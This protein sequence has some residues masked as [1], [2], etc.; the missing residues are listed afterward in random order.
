LP[1]FVLGE[2]LDGVGDGIPD[3]APT[4]GAQANLNLSSC[5]YAG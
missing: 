4:V 3:E 5:L 1:A 2:E